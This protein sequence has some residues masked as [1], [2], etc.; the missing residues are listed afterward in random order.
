MRLVLDR[1]KE[2]PDYYF[3][4]EAADDPIRFVPKFI[5]HIKGEFAGKPFV[6]DPIQR[7]IVEDIY[8]WK[9]KATRLRRF[10]DVWWEGAIG[11]GK[12]PTLAALGL[13]E[14]LAGGE[15]GAEI[16][17][18]ASTFSQARNVFDTAKAMVKASPELRKRLNVTQYAIKHRFSPSF[19]H[20]ISGRGPKGGAVPQMVLA[21]EIHEWGEAREN[22]DTLQQRMGKRRQPLMI[23]ATNAGESRQ[24][25][26]WELHEEAVGVL[27]G[28]IVNPKLYP[29][30]WAA[31]KDAEPCEDSWRA[32]NPLLGETVAVNNAA[33]DWS[34]AKGNP[35]LETRH[36]RLYMGQWR[37]GSKKWIDL[38]KWK[39]CQGS[40]TPAD[41][42]GAALYVGVDLSLDD[43]LSAVVFVWVK[44]GR[45]YVEARFWVPKATADHYYQK[46][47]VKYPTWATGKHIT[48]ID[49]PTISPA[50]KRR[51]AA[52]IIALSKTYPIKAVCY[53]RYRSD[54]CVA[55]LESAGLTCLPIA[56]GYS[57][58]PG[59][60]ELDR[61]MKEKSIVI[62]PN[63]VLDFCAENVEVT[64]DQRGNFWPIKP[65]A[66]G[67]YAGKR[68]MKIDGISALVTALTEARRDSFARARNF[69]GAKII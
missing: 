27:E 24:S 53:D 66:K 26:C 60:S 33:F 9:V 2:D 10:T 49:E 8:G 58:S 35:A 43:D 19:W 34:R 69:V 44:D 21:D 50:V 48:L 14:L 39:L 31:D 3:D 55:E 52:D 38:T 29:V 5:C 57:V 20:I 46:Y 59:C 22:Y 41:L 1:S 16:Y 4:A 54:D 65:N 28:K 47:N 13:Y 40:F 67:T 17:S 7:A 6:F 30:I 18:C 64:Y 51:I 61:R 62:Q 68:E 37:Q 63:G 23:C 42:K 56:Q 45:M 12:S 36:R 32:A 25:L 15:P 11:C